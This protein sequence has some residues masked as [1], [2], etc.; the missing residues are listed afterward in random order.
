[1]HTYRYTQAVL[2]LLGPNVELNVRWLD[3]NII[4]LFKRV[5]HTYW[6]HTVNNLSFL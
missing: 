2:L 3:V 6:A 4:F 5:N 1:M